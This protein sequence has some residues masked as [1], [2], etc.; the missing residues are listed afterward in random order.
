MNQFI[1]GNENSGTITGRVSQQKNRSIKNTFQTMAAQRQK[2]GVE[3]ESTKF[4]DHIDYPGAVGPKKQI[5]VPKQLVLYQLSKNV[6]AELIE[7]SFS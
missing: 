4:T 1:V 6:D 2:S 7:Q 5:N 3:R